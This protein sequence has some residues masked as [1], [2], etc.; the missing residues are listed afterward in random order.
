MKLRHFLRAGEQGGGGGGGG[1]GQV[2]AQDA[3]AFLTN[4]GH[5]EDALKGM[6]DDKVLEL[7]GKVHG[8]H[9]KAIESALKTHTEKAPVF[10]EKWR[11]H[12][13]GEDQDALKQLARYASP[14]DVWKKARE[15]EKKMS[16]GE[17]KAVTAF[18][19]KGTAE[20]QTAWRKDHGIPEKPEAY[21]LTLGDGLVI[22]DDDKPLVNEFLKHA[23]ATHTPNEGVKQTLKWFLG[24]YREQVESGRAEAEKGALQQAEDQ[25]RKDWGADYRGNMN[26]IAGLLDAHVSTDSGLKDRILKSVK[27]EPEFAKLWATLARETNP[28]GTLVSG[29]PAKMEQ[30]IGDEI[31]KYEGWMKA[32]RGTKEGDKYWKDEKVQARYRELLGAR[33][34]MKGKAKA[35]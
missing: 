35:A 22:G 16:S 19:E 32:G 23:H 25:L 14:A 8:S 26:A 27:L 4:Y 3:R 2:S 12:I 30:T 24:T 17:L 11:E 7:H 21:D 28:A 15:L 1:G 34:K 33:D 31:S 20:E 10:G 18:P 6:A 5:A 9:T 13:A 29:D